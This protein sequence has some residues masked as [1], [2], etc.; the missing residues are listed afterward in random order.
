[1][2][3]FHDVMCGGSMLESWLLGVDSFQCLFRI[4][5]LKEDNGRLNQ[6]WLDKG[7]SATIR[8]AQGKYAHKDIIRRCSDAA[9][10]GISSPDH[11]VVCDHGT[12]RDP[13]RP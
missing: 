5:R 7:G 1:M 8:M 6:N 12:L 2:I 10:M 3:H 11:L 13:S 4:K 9:D